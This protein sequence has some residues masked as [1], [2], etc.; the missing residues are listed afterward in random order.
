[1]KASISLSLVIVSTF[2][3][4]VSCSIQDSN[5]ELFLK[6]LLHD[7]VEPSNP[8]SELIYTRN[9]SSF[10]SV[11]N[12]YIK[13]RRFLTPSTPKPL[14]I[15]TPNHESHVQATIKCSNQAGLQLRIRSGGHDYEGLSYTSTVPFVVLDM[16]NLRKIDINIADETAWVQA[17]ATIGELY[18]QISNVSKLHAFPAG[19]CP[20]MGAGGHISGG[21]Y[22]NL[23]RKYGLSSDNVVDAQLVD[24]EGRILNRESMGEDL[25]WA[26]RGGGGESFGVI[27]AWKIKLVSVPEKVTVFN[28][29]KTTDQATSQGA[30][31]V[32]YKWQ[33]VAPK[34]PGELF[35]RA[36]PKVV[37]GSRPLEKTILVSFIGMFLGQISSLIPLMNQQFPE[38]G[39]RAEDCHE[40]SWVESTLFWDE[41]PIGT[42]IN[43]LLNR[44]TDVKFSS[45]N[46]SDYV[47][48]VI[49]KKALEEIWTKM[50]NFGNMWMQWNPYGGRMSEISESETAFPHRA[51]NLFKIQ[52][53]ALWE[54]EG[55][56]STNLYTSK[57]RDFYASMAPYVSNSPR[58][59]FL[60][61]R[62][63]DIGNSNP[64][65]KTSLLSDADGYGAK[66]FKG[67]YKR[68]VE[69]K[70]KVDPFNFFKNEQSIPPGLV[71]F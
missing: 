59:A 18:Y 62:D 16:F 29:G 58:E 20:T 52:Y 68:L 39:L 21:G 56:N 50:I 71:N 38:L 65:N 7:H 43:V 4:S 22:G 51:G 40:M 14:A 33:Q 9:N 12:A 19:V 57:I 61:Y 46:K 55:I 3:L 27:L 26:I 17:G 49:P 1:M 2:F 30:T 31:D 37:N 66:Y 63:L 8:I 67:N 23:M 69:V 60:N 5:L 35:I 64:S 32:I 48:N 45:K 47:K 53:C 41:Y 42:S 10:Q 11:L 44:S 25:F 34:L 70:T 13:N 28:V 15:V 54:E 6:C 24:V 36:M